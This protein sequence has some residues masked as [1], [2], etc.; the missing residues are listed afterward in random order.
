MGYV[1]FACR[2]CRPLALAWTAIGKPDGVTATAMDLLG[3]ANPQAEESEHQ[4]ADH[5]PMERAAATGHRP[6]EA[7]TNRRLLGIQ[8]DRPYPLPN[9]PLEVVA[10][11]SFS[12]LE[13]LFEGR[14]RMVWRMDQTGG[15][16]GAASV[17]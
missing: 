4:L 9:R 17:H 13:F 2:F 16:N 8:A 14:Y 15:G 12:A 7:A 11:L 5:Q 1:I 6:L 10:C 3:A